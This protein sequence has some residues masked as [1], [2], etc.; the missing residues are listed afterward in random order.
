MN[1]KYMFSENKSAKTQPNKVQSPCKPLSMLERF[2][3]GIMIGCGITVTVYTLV[4]LMWALVT[5]KG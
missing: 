4:L 1:Y 3:V 2:G 5:A